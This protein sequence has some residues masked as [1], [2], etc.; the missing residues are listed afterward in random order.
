[1]RQCNECVRKNCDVVRLFRRG[2]VIQNKQIVDMSADC[3]RY[4]EPK[5]WG[6]PIILLTVHKNVQAVH[7]VLRAHKLCIQELADFPF[8]R[9]V[10]EN[11]S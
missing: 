9:I 11:E 10:L 7:D 1:M 2:R 6:V 8:F 5:Q 3:D 4:M